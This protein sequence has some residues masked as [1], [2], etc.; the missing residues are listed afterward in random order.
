[1]CERLRLACVVFVALA[2]IM[3]LSL[4]G[5][6]RLWAGGAKEPVQL[7]LTTARAEPKEKGVLFRCEAVLINNTTEVLNV[8]SGYY[9][10]YDGLHLV[11]L[12]EDGKR[13]A[14]SWYIKYK[15]PYSA[16]GRLFPLEKGENRK[17]LTFH[18]DGL[19]KDLKTVKV[20]LVGTLPGQEYRGVFC[21][22]AVSVS[23]QGK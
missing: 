17:L 4:T 3:S 6:N 15:S 7:K 5:S 18:V 14:Q 20:L 1:M 22:D 11:V 21:S 13:L 23:L 2:G 8:K 12:G 16:E 9:S 10:A 19:P